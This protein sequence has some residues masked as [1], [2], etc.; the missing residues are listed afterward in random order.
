MTQVKKKATKK[1]VEQVKEVKEVITPEVKE[2]ATVEA[3]NVPRIQFDFASIMAGKIN[4]VV[5]TI[6]EQDQELDNS[7]SKF[8]LSN[9]KK[10][11]GF[12]TDAQSLRHVIKCGATSRDE[13]DNWIYN[14]SVIMQYEIRKALKQQYFKHD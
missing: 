4:E 3:V 2:E 5:D 14:M 8:E 12:G 7:A 10:G 1:A 11:R 6:L 13:L 9:Y